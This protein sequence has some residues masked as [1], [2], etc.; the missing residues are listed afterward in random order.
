MYLEYTKP[1][2]IDWK[3]TYSVKDKIPFG[4]FVLAEELPKLFPE[5]NI[6]IVENQTIAEF[7][8]E[9]EELME[10]HDNEFFILGSNF[11]SKTDYDYLLDFVKIGNDVFF[12]TDYVHENLSNKLKLTKV[13]FMENFLEKDN[14]S[15]YN[16]LCNSYLDT[17]KYCLREQNYFACFSNFDKKNAVVLGQCIDTAAW[18][19]FIKTPYGAGNFYIH[20][21]PEAFTNYYM[22]NDTVFEYAVNSLNYLKK[23]NIYIFEYKKSAKADEN[24]SLL[25]YIFANPPLHWAWL[26]LLWSAAAYALFAGKRLQRIIPII[27]PLKNS[28]EEFTQTIGDMYY[29]SRNFSDLIDKKIKYFLFFVKENYYLDIKNVNSDFSH[30]LSSKSGVS[31]EITDKIVFL[32]NKNNNTEEDLK[33]INAE[34]EMFFKLLLSAKHF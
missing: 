24:K 33:N 17:T 19:N 32:I 29:N 12:A 6:E 8:I 34:I 26:I 14:K 18:A 13:S 3:K 28:T 27:K 22:L 11:L 31:K 25:M 15:V 23:S 9:N 30:L 16:T 2:P 4:A 20:L 1:Q 21:L 10:K 7:F 5:K